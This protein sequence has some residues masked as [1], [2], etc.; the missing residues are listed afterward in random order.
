MRGWDTD[1]RSVQDVSQQH[2]ELL[3]EDGNTVCTQN[4]RG[5][6]WLAVVIQA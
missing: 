6:M 2:L 1:H 5:D 3:P 4:L